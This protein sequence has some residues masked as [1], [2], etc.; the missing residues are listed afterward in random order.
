MLDTI[1]HNKAFIGG[2]AV[3]VIIGAWF[4]LGGEPAPQENGLV[5]E[6]F[7]SPA[8]EEERDL[9]ATLLQLKAVELN[10]AIFSNPA[11]QSLKDFGSQIV[12]EPVGRP[13]PFAP[14]TQTAGAGN[15]ATSSTGNRSQRQ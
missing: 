9:V 2:L 6:T 7:T 8:T 14:L 15:T 12:P 3:I 1:L 10:A 4:F 11:F 5:T 13:N